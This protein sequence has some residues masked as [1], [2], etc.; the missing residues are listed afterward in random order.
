[1]NDRAPPYSDEALA[2]LR[3]RA[4]ALLR[5]RMRGLR[6]ALPAEA[7]RRRSEA[8]CARVLALPAWRSARC[9][10]LFVASEHEVH[11]DA[12]FDDARRRGLTVLV[13]RV[14]DDS[15]AMDLAVFRNA[16]GEIP[17]VMSA[18]GVMEPPPDAPALDPA[19]VDLVLVPAL[20]VD[21]A[22]HRLGYGRAHYDNTLPLATRAL[23]VA[24]AFDFQ[25]I[26]EVPAE[27]HD[28]PVQVV[29]TDARTLDLAAPA[30]PEDP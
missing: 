26:A 22:G 6:A 23:R 1:M 19:E 5:K 21:A 20:V 24:V 7:V 18:F 25:L 12:L 13:P 2:A 10:A 30:A 16:D 17:L 4:K 3:P 11:L 29:I 9:V 14:R 15:R 27:A 28:V 8:I